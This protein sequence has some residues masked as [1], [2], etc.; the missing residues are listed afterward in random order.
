MIFFAQSCTN[1]EDKFFMGE[2]NIHN[3][4]EEEGDE[5]SSTFWVYF[6][7]FK[8]S[9]NDKYFYILKLKWP[10]FYSQKMS[11]RFD[12]LESYSDKNHI[13]QVYI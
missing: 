5:G 3:E 12:Y 8:P 10:S 1:V 9:N 2:V 13:K 7:V 11:S 6:S 4:E